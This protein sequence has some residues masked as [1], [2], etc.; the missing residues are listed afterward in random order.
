[1]TRLTTQTCSR[2]RGGLVPVLVMEARLRRDG[3]GRG[4]VVLRAR[5]KKEKSRGNVL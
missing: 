1:M 4:Q 5:P 3:G 2:P